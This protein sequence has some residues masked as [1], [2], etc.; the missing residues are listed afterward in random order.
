VDF[1][2]LAQVE[3][4]EIYPMQIFAG[5]HAFI[6]RTNTENNCNTY[7]I[8][9][10]LKTIIDPGHRHLFEHVRKGLAALNTSPDRVDL[11]IVTHGHPDHMEAVQG[12]GKDTLFA[13]NEEEYRFINDLAGQ[14]FRIPKPHF[15]LRE[16]DL[17]IGRDRFEVIATPGHSPGSICL[18]WPLKKALFTG[19]LI[20]SGSIG[21]T[22]LPGG[23]G[24]MLKESIK[25]ISAMDIDYLLSG[26]GEIVAGRKEVQ[27][28]FE[29]IKNYWFDYL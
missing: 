3:T 23:S 13:M 9:G 14:Y 8:D 5:L 7:F 6:W 15:F 18:Y 17:T 4:K 12:L 19:D 10:E 2:A 20:F 11:A 28:N 25:R 22:D 27:A 29:K 21:R 24:G 16:G 1:K 26:H